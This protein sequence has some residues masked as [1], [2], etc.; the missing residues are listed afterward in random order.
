MISR[1]LPWWP[2]TSLRGTRIWVKPV[3]R[4]APTPTRVT[5]VIAV[6][7]PASEAGR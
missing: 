5:P 4:P 2:R 6:A 1:N 3:P 7:Q